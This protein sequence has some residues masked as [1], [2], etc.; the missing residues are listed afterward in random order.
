ML[1]MRNATFCFNIITLF[2]FFSTAVCQ[3]QKNL[4]M[5]TATKKP[6]TFSSFF[7]R[8]QVNSG[9]VPPPTTSPYKTPFG[10][11]PHVWTMGKE[12]GSVVACMRGIE[13]KIK[14]SSTTEGESGFSLLDHGYWCRQMVLLRKETAFVCLP[15]HNPSPFG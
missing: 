6:E 14:V 8:R 13:K 9:S 10:I 7:L 11:A 12:A 3:L 2:P 4:E 1:K 5:S 15:L